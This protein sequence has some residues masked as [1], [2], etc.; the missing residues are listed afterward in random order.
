M[1][2]SNHRYPSLFAFYF[3]WFWRSF[4]F[5]NKSLLS[6]IVLSCSVWVFFFVAA[7]AMKMNTAVWLALVR[8]SNEH[9]IHMFWS[10]VDLFSAMWNAKR[11]CF[12]RENEQIQCEDWHF[13]RIAW[14]KA[15]EHDSNE[16][17]SHV[18][19]MR[20][21]A[22]CVCV[23]KN[24]FDTTSVRREK[25]RNGRFYTDCQNDLSK[26]FVVWYVTH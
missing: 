17:Q 11:L 13:K 5:C 20:M 15:I 8:L 14:S 24:K 3:C 1:T 26:E 7:D 18:L 12:V 4:S 9:V 25:R 2:E 10:R 21:S 23:L 19:R 16:A 22:A 6:W